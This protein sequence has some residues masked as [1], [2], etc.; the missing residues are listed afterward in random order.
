MVITDTITLEDIQARNVKCEFKNLPKDIPLI[1]ACENDFSLFMTHMLGFRPYAWQYLVNNKLKSVGENKIVF[2]NSRQIGKSRYI[3][4]LALW[5]VIFNHGY[6]CRPTPANANEHT[7][8]GIVSRS[9]DQAKKLIKS[10]RDALKKG[11]AHMAK[12]KSNG[13]SLYGK[14]WFTSKIASVEEGQN[15]MN[16]ITFTAGVGDA[17]VGSFIQCLP[18][19]D[20]I[21]GN[22]FTDLYLDEAA[23]IEDDIIQENA[24]PTLDAMGNML[25]I[26]STPVLPDGY[27]YKRVDPY[28]QFGENQFARFMFTIEALKDDA[29]EQYKKVLA[30]I[31]QLEE[32]GKLNEVQRNY[33]CSFISTETTFFPLDRVQRAFD[34]TL[35]PLSEYKDGVVILGIDFGGLTKSH[36][37]ITA[38]SPPDFG[39]VSRR[40]KCWRYP[41]RQDADIIQDIEEIIMP[42]FNVSM[43]V[44]DFCPASYM[45]TQLMERKGWPLTKFQF[46]RTTKPDF[47]DRFRRRL[48]RRL[49]ISYKDDALY[50]E[51]I[52]YGDDMKPMGENTDDLIDSWMLGCVPFLE[53]KS[54]IGAMIINPDSENPYETPEDLIIAQENMNKDRKKS[55]L[56]GSVAI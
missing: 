36:T 56:G 21:L 54:R 13:K 42:Y 32:D 47:M 33:Y 39:N 8:I 50:E 7:A 45:M 27:F 52:H 11:D 28:G 16:I 20:A 25:V 43:I 53:Q 30:E 24:M 15:N 40:L 22:T 26:A 3:A 29:P 37:V 41:L 2:C 48:S 38:V 49:N 55:M 31:K 51:L 4:A 10:I 12:Y 17:V 35:F 44:V 6:K 5:R 18:P 46:S 19:T 9:A 23:R 34:E 1:K 14:D